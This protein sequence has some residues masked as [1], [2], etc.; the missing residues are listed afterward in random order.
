MP[1]YYFKNKNELV[2]VDHETGEIEIG[3]Q[4]GAEDTKIEAIAPRGG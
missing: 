2:H 3:S 1:Y 4:I